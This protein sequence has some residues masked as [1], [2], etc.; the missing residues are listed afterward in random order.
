MYKYLNCDEGGSFLSNNNLCCKKEEITKILKN[1]AARVHFVGVGGVGMYSLFEITKKM[2]CFVS[3]S[4]REM[5]RFTE[6][7]LSLGEK[8]CIGHKGDFVRGCNLVVYTH[9]V[10][11]DNPEIRF[12]RESGIP[13]VSRAEYLGA[14]MENYDTKIGVSGTHGKSSVT[15]M[16]SRIFEAAGK[17]PTTVL[18]ALI[19]ETDSPIKIGGESY[20]IYEACEYKDSFLSFSPTA[21]VYTNLEFDHTDYFKDIK[22]LESS[23]LKSMNSADLCIVNAD[24][25]RLKSLIP[26]I[27]G[28]V[29]TYGVNEKSDYRAEII[30]ENKGFYS[31]NVYFYE[32]KVSTVRLSIPGR[33]NVSNALGA[34]AL[35]HRLG[36]NEEIISKALFSFHGIERRIE[37]IADYG[38]LRVYYDYAHHPTEIECTVKALREMTD[39]EIYVIFKPHTYSRTAGLFD[40]FVKAL[41]LADAVYLCDISA[42]REEAIE[43]VS[44][45]ALAKRIGNKAIWAEDEKI[46]SIIDSSGLAEKSGAL[47]IMGAANMDYFKKQFFK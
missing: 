41:S 16:L 43:G 6:R 47:I 9:A 7:L 44:S 36:I 45:E 14:L 46:K 15:A 20:F 24:D 25:E 8:I 28:D 18:G 32:K 34:F 22:S 2:G 5:S 40:G 37:H 30:E 26:Y 11:N 21:A 23:F 12:A 33:F 39:G 13:T 4:D 10:A 38:N 17:N 42:I 35:A 1:G 29:V 3:G 19:P 27:K 31:F